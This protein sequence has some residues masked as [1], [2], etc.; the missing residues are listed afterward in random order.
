MN[1]PKSAPPI[2]PFIDTRWADGLRGIASL[3]VVASHITLCFARSVVPPAT[4]RDGPSRPFQRPYL[5]LIGQ[6]NAAVAVFFVLLGFVNSLKTI[7]LSRSGRVSDGLL[8]LSTASFRRTSRLVFPAAIVTIISWFCCQIGLYGLSRKSDAYWLQ[9]TTPEPSA[10][11]FEAFKSLGW[12]LIATWVKADNKYDQPQWALPHLFLGSLYIYMVLLATANA[13]PAF[14]L[15]AEVALWFWGWVA[16]DS[17]IQPNV[18]AGMILAELSFLPPPKRSSNLVKVLPFCGVALGLYL[19][20][21]P[22][23]FAEYAPWSRQLQQLGLNI[24]PKHAML[25]RVWPNLGAQ[26]LCFSVMYSPHMRQVLSTAWL[27]WLGGLSFSIYL[28][29]GPLMRTVLAWVVF[30]PRS[31][32]E[33]TPVTGETTVDSSGPIPQ[34]GDLSIA[35]R[36]PV[37]LFI[38]LFVARTW[39][40]RVEPYL[41]T[42]TI[43]LGKFSQSFAKDVPRFHDAKLVD[44]EVLPSWTKD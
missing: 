40:K 6:G 35:L 31:I 4:S 33:S 34:P 24:F 36:I 16:R 1:N 32:L 25:G 17:I 3:F 28:L 20:S 11:W 27:K 7:Q 29:H 41:A 2:K 39:N 37:F 22:D 8:A 9:A 30:G 15:A 12:E 26:V 18:Y 5:R 23:S 19:C 43:N 13:T 21:Y 44:R 42:A 38:L 14:R 10:S